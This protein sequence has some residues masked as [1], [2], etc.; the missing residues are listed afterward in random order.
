M[1]LAPARPS[2]PFSIEGHSINAQSIDDAVTQIGNALSA[3]D[4]FAVFTINLDHVVKLR[5]SAEFRNA[6]ARARFVL[7]DGQPI[8]WLGR[9]K[10]ANVQRTTG[11]DLI[12]PL[13][14]EAA[15]RGRSIFLFGATA[16][17][18]AGAARHLRDV[19][20]G[21]EIADQY[22]PPANFDPVG[23]EADA[24]IERIKQSGAGVC[25][26]ALGAPKQ[27][28]FAARA[29]AANV[30]CAFACIGAGLDFLAGTQ[31][32]AP[33]FFQKYAIEWL[34]RLAHQPRRLAGRY[35]RSAL[36]FAGLLLDHWRASWSPAGN[37]PELH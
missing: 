33:A 25:F 9:L 15:R 34:W 32:R 6:Y 11:S 3:Q 20:P 29:V 28:L 26:V 14:Q 22:A 31:Q 24:A 2:R 10:G 5:Q 30:P 35:A 16:E 12:I 21:L 23:V 1:L 7:A 37:K 27:E 13:C 4:G 8:V 18:L 36:A 19:S 17:A